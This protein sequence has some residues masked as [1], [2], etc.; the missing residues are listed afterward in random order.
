MP[1]FAWLIVL[2]SA[3]AALG[4]CANTPLPP[5]ADFVSPF[6]GGISPARLYVAEA[7]RIGGSLRAYNLLPICRDDFDKAKELKAL[8]SSKS[9][10]YGDLTVTDGVSVLASLSGLPVTPSVSASAGLGYS[11]RSTMTLKNTQLVQVDNE[12]APYVIAD[13]LKRRGNG[14]PMKPTCLDVVESNLANQRMVIVTQAVLSTDTAAFGPAAGVGGA[15]CGPS[16]DKPKKKKKQQ[17]D[18]AA[19]SRSTTGQGSSDNDAEP[20]KKKKKKGS[21]S[22]TS[23]LTGCVGVNLGKAFNINVRAEGGQVYTQNVDG[24]VIAI[25]P[26]DLPL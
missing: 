26:K 24:A 5:G 15:N 18:E 22:V 11:D 23:P 4:G 17:D 14:T 13:Y 6:A 3:G 8:T 21:G 7:R 10:T 16:A 12:G 2:A 19:A 9:L 25:I 1:K 20:Q